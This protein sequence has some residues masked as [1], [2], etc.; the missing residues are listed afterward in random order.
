MKN[1]INKKAILN[2]LGYQNQV[3][4]DDFL[5][6]M[7][8]AIDTVLA[9]AKPNNIWKSMLR[10][11]LNLVLI[12]EDINAHLGNAEQVI[13]MAATLGQEVDFILR[14]SQRLDMKQ[15]VILDASASVII[16][17]Y[18]DQQEDFL[19]QEFLKQGKYLS[20][21]F[22]PG[23]GDLPLSVQENF[24][25]ILDTNRKIGVTVL[26]NGLMSPMKSITCIMAILDEPIS[27][28]T[29][30][31]SICRLKGD[32]VLRRRGGYCGRFRQ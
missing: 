25:K 13:L 31:C 17:T 6:E 27:K 5:A 15:A 20:T 8:E 1:R 18:L 21:R 12:G 14:R 7:D 4:S 11:E 9:A 26:N 29:D 23:Y 22:S 16:E 30:P 2:Y 10:S 24:L 28:V 19:R 32:C 3:L